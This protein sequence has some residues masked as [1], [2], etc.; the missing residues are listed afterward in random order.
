METL[1]EDKK[2]RDIF[3]ALTPYWR[4]RLQSAEDPGAGTLLCYLN[5]I[6]LFLHA[7]WHKCIF[8]RSDKNVKQVEQYSLQCTTFLI[9]Q[10]ATKGGQSKIWIRRVSAVS[11]TRYLFILLRETSH[12][13]QLLWLLYNRHLYKTSH[14]F[15][16]T[17]QLLPPRR[18]PYIP[19]AQDSLVAL[20][21][22]FVM[23]PHKWTQIFGNW[24]LVLIRL[25]MLVLLCL[26]LVLLRVK[27]K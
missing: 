1:R 9:R 13:R 23:A 14:P 25:V 27:L 10:D 19:L 22:I 7:H 16:L 18:N 3:D 12:F 11:R 4:R 8:Y 17:H 24:L 26:P 6:T 2:Y 5:F 21:S 15:S 20:L